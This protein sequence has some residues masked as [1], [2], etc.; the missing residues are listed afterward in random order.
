MVMKFVYLCIRLNQRLNIYVKKNLNLIF[1]PNKFN[2]SKVLKPLNQCDYSKVGLLGQG[3]E[4]TSQDGTYL[5]NILNL[6]VLN[7]NSN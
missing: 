2:K 4:R 1:K 7:R 3:F 6:N 5:P